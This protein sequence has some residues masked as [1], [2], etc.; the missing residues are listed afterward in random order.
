[1]KII[2]T[3]DDG[4][5]TDITEGV[6]TLYDHVLGSLDWQSNFFDYEEQ[7]AVIRTGIA[8]GFPDAEKY[9]E[10]IQKAKLA[11]EKRQEEQVR[12]RAE[13]RRKAEETR[14]SWQ[15]IGP[16]L[17]GLRTDEHGVVHGVFRP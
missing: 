8:C 13:Q 7:A 3:R 14:A 1:M 12:R 2:A 10:G 4:T 17:I 16:K 9:L 15:D 5:T 11:E 6:Q